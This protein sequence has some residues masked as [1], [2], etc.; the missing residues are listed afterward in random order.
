M[1]E[2]CGECKYFRLFKDDPGIFVLSDGECLNRRITKKEKDYDEDA[3]NLFEKK[4]RKET[5]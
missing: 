2:T 5:K 4:V 3:C 1:S